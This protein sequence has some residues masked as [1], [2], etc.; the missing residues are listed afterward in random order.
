MYKQGKSGNPNGRPKGAANKNSKKIRQL[1]T[2]VIQ[3]G[4]TNIEA[5]LQQLTAYA[6]T[7]A[8]ADPDDNEIVIKL[9]DESTSHYNPDTWQH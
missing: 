4:L 6:L 1:L 9:V 7:K 2:E 3:V 5:D 8:A